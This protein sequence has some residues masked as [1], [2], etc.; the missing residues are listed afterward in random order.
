[1]GRAVRAPPGEEHRQHAAQ[2]HL[3]RAAEEALN[4]P[5][6]PELIREFVL[7]GHGNFDRVRELLGEH[8][9]LLNAGHRWAP[10]D[11]ETALGAASHVGNAAIANFL[12]ER[13]APLDI[14]AAAMLARTEA[15]E[16]M[17]A[18]DPALI[19]ATGAH[20]IPLLTHAAQSGSVPLVEM[21]VAQG[22][23]DGASSALGMAVARNDAAMA[24]WLLEHTTPDLSWKNFQGKTLLAMAAE[25]GADDIIALLR[26][27]GAVE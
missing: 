8:P 22:A 2:V 18:R 11:V 20:K 9:A 23:T 7:A 19:R 4:A 13:G 5:P 21:L 16:A 24:R 10:D 14:C 27:A 25:R 3:L 17:L 12:L 6:A 26:A 1:V 15:V